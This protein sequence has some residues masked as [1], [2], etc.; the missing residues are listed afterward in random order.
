MKAAR[1][2][3][4][5]R[6]KI[7]PCSLYDKMTGGTAWVEGDQAQLIGKGK[8]QQ[9]EGMTA[10]QVELA[11]T[12]EAG[13]DGVE[14]AVRML[15]GV[16]T[17]HAEEAHGTQGTGNMDE[18][19][20]KGGEGGDEVEWA[21]QNAWWGWR[22][23]Y[24]GDIGVANVEQVRKGERAKDKAGLV[25]VRREHGTVTHRVREELVAA[26]TKEAREG[27]EGAGPPTRPHERVQMWNEHMPAGKGSGVFAQGAPDGKEALDV[28]EVG[29]A[30][31][32][33][34]VLSLFGRYDGIET[35][36]P[37]RDAGG[38]EVRLDEQEKTHLSSELAPAMNES[39]AR[40]AHALH[41]VHKYR[42]AAA[43]DGS[44]GTVWNER[45]QIYEARASYGVYEGATGGDNVADAAGREIQEELRE[46]RARW[47][48]GGMWGAALPAHFEVV[49]A[50]LAGALM[51]LR[52]VV[53]EEDAPG[54]RGAKSCRCLLIM[55]C[56]GAMELMEQAWRKG[57]AQAMAGMG[58]AGVLEAICRC[59][60]RLDLVTCMYCPAHIGVSCSAYAD[61]VAKEY[62][63]VEVND[64]DRELLRQVYI[65]ERE[66]RGLM[67]EVGGG[68]EDEEG[69]G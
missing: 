43:T 44:K 17:R 54:G 58:R 21:G 29:K 22:T 6:R 38:R 40:V 13:E 56:K 47:V 46:K 31:R 9:T 8:W 18:R 26:V 7:L 24:D 16:L 15:W 11:V 62:L 3:E 45:R 39:V 55:D 36:E 10:A 52:K 19:P 60:R 37:V 30:V 57:S 50:E 33:D 42:R 64:E 28:D 1:A 14:R 66:G 27:R 67:Y 68:R 12:G 48:G 53:K 69:S 51:Y 20:K 61:G 25:G 63:Q 23:Y 65:R 41:M 35:G 59:R 5:K 49:D 34:P 4:A 2:Q 32:A